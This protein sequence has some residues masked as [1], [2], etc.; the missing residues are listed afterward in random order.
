MMISYIMN[1]IFRQHFVLQHCKSP[2]PVSDHGLVVWYVLRSL[3][4][5]WS[6]PKLSHNEGPV[7]HGTTEPSAVHLSGKGESSVRVRIIC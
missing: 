1:S 4:A 2:C 6:H 5:R 7:P 3:S